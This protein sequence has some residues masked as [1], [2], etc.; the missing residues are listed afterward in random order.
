MEDNERV[1][2][3]YPIKAAM[4]KISG[5]VELLIKINEK[6][7]VQEYKINKSYP[8]RLFDE[9]AQAS[10][11]TWKYKPTKE[12]TTNQPV[13]TL[14]QMD[15]EFSKDVVDSSFQKHCISK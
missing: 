8:K 1:N 12:N 6:G 9:S 15:F 14:V 11:A 5:C 10:L 13:L 7:D 4:K 3:K 2:P